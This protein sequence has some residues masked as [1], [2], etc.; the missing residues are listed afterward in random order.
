MSKNI[1]S[2]DKWSREM[3]AIS[4]KKAAQT[5][6]ARIRCEKA[7]LEFSRSVGWDREQVIQHCLGG[8]SGWLGREV[9]EESFD[10][11]SM[12][13]LGEYYERLGT[14]LGV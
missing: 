8:I 10:D 5:Y 12:K 9:F 6:G 4:K 13:I 14:E 2:Y 1:E 7:L 3:K 11:G